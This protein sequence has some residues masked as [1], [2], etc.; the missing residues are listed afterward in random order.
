M[1]VLEHSGPGIIT[2]TMLRWYTEQRKNLT[3]DTQ[4]R[5]YP[6]WSVRV[7]P[8]VVWGTHPRAGSADGVSQS[9]PEVVV[10]H[11]FAGSWKRKQ[12]VERLPWPIRPI[13]RSVVRLR[14]P[15]PLPPLAP[16]VVA[17]RVKPQPPGTLYPVS[18]RVPLGPGRTRA[19]DV[20]LPPP[21]VRGVPNC[22]AQ[23][24]LH[25]FN[26]GASLPR[27]EPH[28]VTA[29]LMLGR[30]TTGVFVD[31]G[32]G[33]G[34]YAL[35]A[36]SSN[37]PVVAFEPHGSMIALLR[38]SVLSNPP[39]RSRIF[40]R[41]Q[42]LGAPDIAL[43]NTAWDAAITARQE[44][45]G[46]AAARGEAAGAQDDAPTAAVEL[47]EHVT[48]L[49]A[50]LRNISA[51]PAPFT[52]KLT[53]AAV[54]LQ[55][56]LLRVAVRGWEGWVLTGA[57]DILSGSAPPAAVLVEC[58]PDKLARTGWGDVSMLV[59]RM[60]AWG[61]THNAHAGP[62]CD[63]RTGT[64]SVGA[65]P[66]S[67]CMLEPSDGRVLASHVPPGASEALLFSRLSFETLQEK[68]PQQVTDE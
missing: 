11:K 5:R 56:A 20:L 8:R 2:D 64:H 35:A 59:E 13:A 17:K 29:L 24:A 26:W 46:A 30:S 14:A 10:A 42:A 3:A 16:D 19:W 49:D 62:G 53:H 55:V 12:G 37:R 4:L 58:V 67:W 38:S 45:L 65:K 21:G 40:M 9:S 63:V 32:A 51:G 43:F 31:V 54:P 27:T 25:I 68:E 34:F 44:K 22:H 39:L 41:H 61:Y 18:C 15:P 52:V 48:S 47:A 23:A 60:R 28:A 7:L 66:G 57:R 33:L 1:F 6:F 50:A 36:A